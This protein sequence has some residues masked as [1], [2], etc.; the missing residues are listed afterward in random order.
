MYGCSIIVPHVDTLPYLKFCVAQIRK[1]RHPE[2]PQ[3][4][5]IPDQSSESVF[6]EVKELYWGNG[7]IQIPRLPKIDHG[8]A[9]DVA[10]RYAVYEYCCFLDCDAFPI[11]RNWLYAPLKLIERY[12]LAF[13]GSNSGIEE[14]YRDH[15][16]FFHIMNCYCLSQTVLCKELAEAVGFIKPENRIKVGFL[17]KVDAWGQG[18]A[19]S[20]VVAQW[21]A[22]QRKMG[23]KLTFEGTSYLGA[24]PWMGIY[25]IVTEGLVFHL[26]FGYAEDWIQDLGETLGPEYLE[27]RERIRR[28]GL[29]EP[30]IREFIDRSVA[31]KNTRRIN[32]RPIPPEIDAYLEE[33]KRA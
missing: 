9:I 27:L 16:A 12:N 8:Y 22:D 19:D 30:L 10:L 5:I 28:D 6:E 29:S 32:G 31:M 20:G 33:L 7:D 13:I 2:I 24:S 17:P 21:Y 3:E 15:G 25:G 26:V 23:D 1:Y 18:G 4:I 11:H 14:S